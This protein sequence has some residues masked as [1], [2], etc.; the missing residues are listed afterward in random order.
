MKYKLPRQIIKHPNI[1]EI[2]ERELALRECPLGE[3]SKKDLKALALV[4]ESIKKSG[5]PDYLV[6]KKISNQIGHGVF[7]HPNAK[8]L[9]KGQIIGP[10]SG[11]L[12]IE[13]ENKEDDSAYAFS[14]LDGL[15]LTKEEQQALDK[16]VTFAPA[17]KYMLNLDANDVGNFTRYINH[18][19]KP[20]IEALIMAIPPNKEGLEEMPIEV[21]YIAKK[22]IL[23]GE[24]LLI[25]YEDEK[26]TYWDAFG[27]KPIVMDPKTYQLDQS[28]NLIKFK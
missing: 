25:C 5:L 21:V 13:L 14:L 4:V 28:L 6:L 10:Y 15:H 19:I 17:R 7:L 12:S 26:E 23:P 2:I 1:K 22:K 16:K 20:N 11:I 8:P 9:V 3:A 27:V 18:C 24:Q